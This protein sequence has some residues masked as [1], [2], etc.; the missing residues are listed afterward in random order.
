[1]TKLPPSDV[2]SPWHDGERA[3]RRRAGVE[4]QMEP[5]GARS[6]INFLLRPH[7]V[8]YAKLPYAIFGTVDDAGDP[9]ATV[10]AGLPGFIQS[11]E[12]THLHI[13]AA[14][15][16]GDP[17]GAGWA[18]GSHVAVLGIELLTRRRIRANGLLEEVT[19]SGTVLRVQQ[20]FGN[21][22]QYIQSRD[23]TFSRD[24]AI[25]W[26][27][28]VTVAAELNDSMRSIIESAD[29]F[30]VASYT[31]RQGDGARSVD[32]SHRG[33][34]AGFVRV[35]AGR[36]SI[37]DFPG[38]RYF[39]TLGNFVHVPRAGLVFVNFTTGDLL[40]LTGDVTI[41]DDSA[42]GVAFSGAERVWHVDVRR[43]V[44]RPG[45]LPLRF[46][47][48]DPSPNSLATGSWT[49]ALARPGE[50]GRIDHWRTFRVASITPE[51]QD[52]SS[53]V[54]SPMDE[55]GLPAFAAGQHVPIRIPIR[56]GEYT[57]ERLY[58]LSSAPQDNLYRI[59]V[60]RDGPVSSALHDVV[61]EGHLVELRAPRGS[62][63]LATGETRPLVLAS[64]GVGITPMV[65]MLR[66]LTHEAR[67]T[68]R[69][70]MTWFVHGARN[71]VAR[72]F[73]AEI[74][75]LVRAS[76][77]AAQLMRFLS[78][79]SPTSVKGVD[80]DTMGRLDA[81]SLRVAVPLQTADIYLCGPNEFM[82]SMYAGLQ[83]LGVPDERIFAESFG[84][85][86]LRRGSYLPFVPI[87]PATASV[88]VHFIRSGRTLV[89]NPGCESLLDLGTFHGLPLASSCRISQC[90]TC[91]VPIRT[92]AVSYTAAPEAGI[93]A[94]TVLLCQALPATNCDL[95][96]IDA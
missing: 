63:T 22:P 52:I 38:N 35:E 64:A 18:T 14:P 40:Q 30:F 49:A 12:A 79:P 23:A 96:E 11:P 57:E 72:A 83:S 68:G 28:P 56:E 87:S 62:F 71:V 19:S 8:F 59:S 5:L 88:P 47:E 90:G 67:R 70:R 32:V 39:N 15:Q 20:S 91:R 66:H 89:W 53:F 51:S 94:G 41:D 46:T 54:L 93:T 80:F 25:R 42:V 6:I 65:S 45:V 75:D 2:S 29:T 3:I 27:G 34:K 26:D 74:S 60:K 55:H 76:R 73:D 82:Q 9:W 17:A 4:E 36:L 50:S 84:P 10:I 95:L 77:G 92:G 44:F 33:G 37:P 13:E 16:P 69:M 31:D 48:G 58:T 7:R 86:G 43:C 81:E 85:A 24:P 21:C 61:C 78:A 1:M